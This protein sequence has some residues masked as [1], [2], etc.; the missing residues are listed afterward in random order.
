MS[1][2]SD[3]RILRAIAIYKAFKC[4]GL[5]LLAA[6]A[7]EISRVGVF[8]HV[9]AW[10]HHLPLAEGHFGIHRAVEALLNLTPGNIEL[11]GAIALGYAILFGIEGYGLWRE[12]GWAEYLTVVATSSLIPFEVWALVD[13]LTLLRVAAIAVNV[14]IVVW[15]V[16]MLLRKRALHVSLDQGAA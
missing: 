6:G 3:Q 11:I 7:L 2:N 15:L 13:K 14:A 10:L 12:R 8:E 4:V 9:V 16:R 1:E 5:L